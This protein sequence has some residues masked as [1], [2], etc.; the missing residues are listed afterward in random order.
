MSLLPVAAGRTRARALPKRKSAACVAG[1][2][3]RPAGSAT[4]LSHFHLDTE[5]G[6]AWSQLLA[7]CPRPPARLDGPLLS[8]APSKE[9]LDGAQGLLV[10]EGRAQLAPN[11][12]GQPLPNGRL[13]ETAVSFA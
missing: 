12:L 10:R 4:R 3:K 8:R 11:P 1:C 9:A 13:A 7:A 6:H 2:R 5:A